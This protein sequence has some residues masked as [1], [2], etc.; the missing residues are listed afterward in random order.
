MQSTGKFELFYQPICSENKD[1]IVSVEA[2]LRHRSHEG[3][4]T[5]PTF[6]T[7]FQLTGM[8]VDL[9]L[10]VIQKALLDFR[11]IDIS[12]DNAL[13]NIAI[14][15]SPITFLSDSF[16]KNFVDIVLSSD[17]GFLR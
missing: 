11:K 13:E 8:I 14:N 2:L 17:V 6:I 5:P 3:K 9:D 15:V 4:I 16:I 12:L 7:D 10:W 1:S